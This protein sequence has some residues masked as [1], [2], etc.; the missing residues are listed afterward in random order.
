MSEEQKAPRG[1]PLA[2]D[3]RAKSGDPDLPAFLARPEGAPVYHGFPIV[4]GITVDGFRLGKIT[5]FEAE[6]SDV[7]DA[8]VVA[9]DGSRAGLV[10]E[11]SKEPHFSEVCVED[12]G[13]WGVWA[14]NFPFPMNSREN[15][16]KNLEAILPPLKEKWEKWKKERSR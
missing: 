14:V 2:L 1:R 13:R 4:D 12:S 3:P 16:Q 7:G 10:W 9:P 6:S 8:F 5:D 11:I 15:I